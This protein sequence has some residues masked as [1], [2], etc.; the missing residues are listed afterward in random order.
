MVFKVFLDANVLLDLT[1]QRGAFEDAKTLIKLIEDKSIKGYTTPSVIHILGHYLTKAY[2]VETTKEIILTILSSVTV[3]DIKH[4]IVL[5][6]LNS[7]INDIEDSLQ[8]YSAIHHKIDYFISMDKK[9]KKY[10]TQNLPIFTP[11]ELLSLLN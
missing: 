6:A 9:L 2:G 11:G 3:I 8:Y 5:L 1:M 10:G 7:R 4:D